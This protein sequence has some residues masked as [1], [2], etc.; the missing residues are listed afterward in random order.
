MNF[1]IRIFI[2]QNPPIQ[3]RLMLVQ[4]AEDEQNTKG[5]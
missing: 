1:I 2:E 3:S 4:S 5:T